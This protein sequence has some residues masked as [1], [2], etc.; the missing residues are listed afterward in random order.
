MEN[1]IIKIIFM[2]NLFNKMKKGSS[3]AADERALWIQAST[4]CC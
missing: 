3:A 2:N 4:P 1:R